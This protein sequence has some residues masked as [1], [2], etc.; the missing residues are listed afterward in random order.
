MVYFFLFLSSLVNVIFV[1]TVPVSSIY[2]SFLDSPLTEDVSP[3]FNLVYQGMLSIYHH[4]RRQLNK[5]IYSFYR[6]MHAILTGRLI[7]NMRRAALRRPVVVSAATF[8]TVPAVSMT[9]FTDYAIELGSFTCADP[10]KAGSQ[11]A[12]IHGSVG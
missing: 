6:V 5:Y 4:Q 11:R 10:A 8:D 3:N 2:L 9:N 12:S 7:L 1:N